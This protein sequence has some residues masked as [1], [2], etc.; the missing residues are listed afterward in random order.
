MV[1]KHEL[2]VQSHAYTYNVQKILAAEILNWSYRKLLSNKIVRQKRSLTD[3]LRAV[4][5][6]CSCAR[7]ALL[8]VVDKYPCAQ[9][10]V[11]QVDQ[12]WQV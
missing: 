5:A 6:V 8:Q 10:I 7:R 12:V 2:H 11:A 9:Q 4:V 1:K 3:V